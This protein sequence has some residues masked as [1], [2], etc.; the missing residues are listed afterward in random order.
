MWRLLLHLR[1]LAVGIADPGEAARGGEALR[2][3]AAAADVRTGAAAAPPTAD[4]RETFQPLGPDGPAAQ[5][6][7]CCNVTKLPQT[8]AALE[9]GQVRYM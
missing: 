4:S 9:R 3:G 8:H 6:S 5:R 2:P 7:S 1:P